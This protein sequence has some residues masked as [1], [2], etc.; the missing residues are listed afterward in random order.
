M[1][2]NIFTQ[3]LTEFQE[4]CK[5]LY[6]QSANEQKRLLKIREKILGLLPFM[7]SK[8]PS[9]ESVK[10]DRYLVLPRKP[11]ISTL[12]VTNLSPV[13]ES[14][15]NSFYVTQLEQNNNLSS[16]LVDTEITNKS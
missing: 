11:R 8:L 14:V 1:Y 12:S 2:V 3:I 6:E 10:F 15:Q 7:N 13:Q 4:I 16:N 9:L 5:D